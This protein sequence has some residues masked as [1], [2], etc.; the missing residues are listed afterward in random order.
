MKWNSKKWEDMS[1]KEKAVGL[2]GL[3]VVGLI[4]FNVI[5]NGTNKVSKDTQIA[6]ETPQ[7]QE[8][9]VNYEI[10]EKKDKGNI[11]SYKVLIKSGNDGKAIAMEVKKECGKPC[12][13]DIYDDKQ[14]LELQKEYDEMMGTLDTKPQDL[15]AWKQKNY[16][17]VADHLV[18]YV[19]FDTG[20]YQEFPYKDWYYKELKTGN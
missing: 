19:S 17:F 1:A 20:E 13:I 8:K 14:A 11:E 7:A 15:Q 2:A 9:T 3:L 10:V 16:V 12:N 18:G 5:S 6:P 4:L